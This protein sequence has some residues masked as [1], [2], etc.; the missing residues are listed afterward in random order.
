M[1]SIKINLQMHERLA[2]ICM[3]ALH[4]W[5]VYMRRFHNWSMNNDGILESCHYE[6]KE[7]TKTKKTIELNTV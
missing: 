7:K 3:H 6:T 1:P 4:R 5:E 2:V